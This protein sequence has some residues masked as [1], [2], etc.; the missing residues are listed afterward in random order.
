MDDAQS[1]MDRPRERRGSPWARKLR[2]GMKTGA[3]LVAV[4]AA[5]AA[6]PLVFLW[7]FIPTTDI[8]SARADSLIVSTAT[9][10]PRYDDVIFASGDTPLAGTLHLPEGP[11]PFPAVVVVH[12]SGRRTA[13]ELRWMGEAWS[14]AG[15]AALTYDKRGVGGSGGTYA[16]VGVPNSERVLT[17]LADDALAGL[18]FLEQQR[19]VLP[20][21]VGLVGVSQ[22]GWIAPLA[23]SRSDDVAFV[24][25]YS[26]PTVSVGEEIFYS[27]LT[28]DERGTTSLSDAEITD[29]LAAY[30]GPRGF[31]PVPALRSM[32]AP[33]LWLLGELDRSI[34][35]PRTVAI[36]DGL[37]AEGMPFEYQ[38]YPGADHS[39]RDRTTGQA[40]DTWPA[41]MA[42]LQEMD[43]K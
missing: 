18:R 41:V 27:E 29:R 40:V 8:S 14:H 9:L 24:V 39:L 43:L 3:L 30:D 34:P 12:G 1:S 11:G 19:D 6:F 28:G 23:A 35:I 13:E 42:W 21:S 16:G 31:D 10:P 4:V 15:F 17:T 38:V 7:L 26:G 37:R 22:G 20:G 2:A 5:L 36:L 33:A 25:L 32:D